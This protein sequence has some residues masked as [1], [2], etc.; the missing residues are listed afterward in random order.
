M[1]ATGFRK[2]LKK[3]DK[4]S[5]SSTKELYLSRQVEIQPCFNNDVLAEL[6]DQATTN[7]AELDNILADDNLNAD[8]SSRN[9]NM[10]ESIDD[11]E[12]DLT[13]ALRD[14]NPSAVAEY[15]AKRGTPLS[16]ATE[17]AEFISRSFLRFCTEG[18]T[19]CLE[20]L[21]ASKEV[22][23]NF[24]DDIS[25]RTCLHELVT[26]GR[27]DVLQKCVQHGANIEATDVYGRTPLHY[28]A[29]YGRPACAIFL[30]QAGAKVHAID[31]DGCM[32]LV[33][34]ITAGH[35][36]CVEILIDNG[37]VVAAHSATAP[38][39]L[40]LACQHGHKD[41]AMLLLSKGAQL[42][43]NAEGLFP[44][45]LTCREGHHEISQLLINHGADV[46]ARDGFNG[47]TPIFYAAAEGHLKC[48][49]VLLSAGCDINVT[50]EHDWSPWTYALY[51]GH[52]Q[53]AR[54]LELKEDKGAMSRDLVVADD[55]GI[56]PM[57][58]S[59][60]FFEEENT[61]TAVESMDLDELP[62]LALP[63]PIIPFRI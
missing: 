28:A 17:D 30:L 62:D 3:W 40:S 56:K 25:G 54:L 23:C 52:M 8:T 33:Y 7:V 5:K 51:R 36:K 10:G 55:I 16:G 44:L 12:S 11:V 15:L 4:R 42:T 34:S 1:N 41:I 24:A 21:L 32:P 63:P 48:V 19:Q 18:N 26:A 53:I 46:N 13:K 39:P 45:H 20:I 31:H 47:W 27:Q 38:I 6:T 60:L 49:Q 29:M 2:I 43:A 14:K 58:P 59:G 50:D 22:D 57:A 35:T 37:A 61:S 9:V